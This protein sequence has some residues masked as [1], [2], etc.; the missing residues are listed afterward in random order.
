MP[1]D[2]KKK[3]KIN[4]VLYFIS[5]NCNAFDWYRY[6]TAMNICVVSKHFRKFKKKYI[7]LKNN[8]FTHTNEM[9]AHIYNK[10]SKN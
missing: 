9:V 1:F 10:N 6:G 4:I 3:R 7:I 2:K 5:N 8:K